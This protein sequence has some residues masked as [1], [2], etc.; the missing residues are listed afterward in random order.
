MKQYT[1]PQ[2]NTKHPPGQIVNSIHHPVLMQEKTLAKEIDS[3]NEREVNKDKKLTDYEYLEIQ[4]FF[5]SM[6]GR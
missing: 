5:N 6:N 1:P 2:H 4:K 3:F